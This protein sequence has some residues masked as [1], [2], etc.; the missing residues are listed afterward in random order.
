MSVPGAQVGRGSVARVPVAARGIIVTATWGADP[1]LIAR[2]LHVRP[3]GLVR[4]AAL[5]RPNRRASAARGAA[6]GSRAAGSAGSV[7]T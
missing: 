6:L 1:G 7:F 2:A 5:G 4:A 3:G